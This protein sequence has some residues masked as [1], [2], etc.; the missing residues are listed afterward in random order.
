MLHKINKGLTFL[1]KV[2]SFFLCVWYLTTKK[3][4][5]AFFEQCILG[6]KIMRQG[7][8]ENIPKSNSLFT[9]YTLIRHL[10]R[11]VV[12]TQGPFG[13]CLGRKHLT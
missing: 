6:C 3:I 8:V 5:F 9:L 4:P 12:E 2:A 10:K 11:Y 7:S 13:S 1:V